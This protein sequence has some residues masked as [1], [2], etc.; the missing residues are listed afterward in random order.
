VPQLRNRAFIARVRGC[1]NNKYA[2]LQ[3]KFSRRLSIKFVHF[4]QYNWLGTALCSC[5]LCTPNTETSLGFKEISYSHIVISKSDSL[6][7][8]ESTFNTYLRTVLTKENTAD[9]FST[10]LL[11]KV[12][13]HRLK[14]SI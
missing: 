10:T 2:W 4:W 8:K 7:R 1:G 14:V 6:R 3:I 13:I 12:D 5:S 9:Q 11:V